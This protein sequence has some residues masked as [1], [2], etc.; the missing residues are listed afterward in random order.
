M[1]TT[2]DKVKP[3]QNQFVLAVMVITYNLCERATI[4]AAVDSF[5]QDL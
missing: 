1:G 4:V 2:G 5:H 3:D